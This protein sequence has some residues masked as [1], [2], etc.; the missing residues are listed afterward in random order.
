MSAT[1]RSAPAA[2]STAY[3]RTKPKA[4]IH[5]FLFVA[6]SVLMLAILLVLPIGQALRDT[7]KSDA[8]WG[9]DNYVRAVKDDHLARLALRH[10]FAFAFFSVIGQYVIGFAVALFQPHGKPVP[11]ETPIMH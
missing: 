9:F 2:M 8:G 11:T 5:P 7:F 4:R 10:T 1:G 6:P 3:K